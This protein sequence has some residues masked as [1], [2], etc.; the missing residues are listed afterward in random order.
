MDLKQLLEDELADLLDD[1]DT[2]IKP[3]ALAAAERATR[4]VEW[5]IAT[6]EVEMAAKYVEAEVA[7][8][9]ILGALGSAK[10][11][12][13]FRAAVANVIGKLAAAALASL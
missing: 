7:N 9:Q 5:G 2:S 4:H 10:A 8:L 12:A 11:Q 6:G 3:R 1:L 13:R